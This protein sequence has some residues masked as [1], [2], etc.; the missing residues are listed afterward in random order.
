MRRSVAVY[1]YL[2]QE[3]YIVQEESGAKGRGA[4]SDTEF[5]SFLV[6]WWTKMEASEAV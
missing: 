3:A 4:A 2:V 6:S 5:T 1:A